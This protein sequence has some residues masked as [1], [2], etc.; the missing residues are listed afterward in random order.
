MSEFLKF[1]DK[2]RETF[3]IHVEIYYSKTLD[4]TITITKK[5]CASDYPKS[6]HVGDDALL[7]QEQGCDMELVFAQAHV[8]LKEWLLEYEG[9]Y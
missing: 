9:G 6:M 8:S 7:M 4:W 5:G 1:V 2:L 3:A